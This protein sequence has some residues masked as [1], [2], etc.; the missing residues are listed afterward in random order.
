MT[1]V[2]Q[3]LG[4]YLRVINSKDDEILDL[5]RGL[6]EHRCELKKR[7]DLHK[8]DVVGTQKELEK[9]RRNVR[10]M[11]QQHR[12]D[13]E[14]INRLVNHNEDMKVQI[15]GFQQKLAE[16]AKEVEQK[17]QEHTR[18]LEEAGQRHAAEVQ[19]LRVELDALRAEQSHVR[20]ER[21][22]ART[23]IE[24]AALREQQLQAREVV[25][26]DLRNSL[27]SVR[28]E[29][30]S[31]VPAQQHREV[32]AELKESLRSLNEKSTAEI[33][34]LK[35]ELSR[36]KKAAGKYVSSLSE[37]EASQAQ[38][39][40]K[41]V[42]A[43]QREE[44]AR[45][46][47]E[48][49]R[50]SSKRLSASQQKEIELARESAEQAVTRLE[51]ATLQLQQ[52][53]DKGQAAE[54]R[55]TEMSEALKQE[56][57]R[58]GQERERMSLQLSTLQTQ[59]AEQQREAERMQRKME[60][61]TAELKVCHAAV[62]AAKEEGLR[63]AAEL[64]ERLSLV[65]AE[66][67]RERGDRE[68]IVFELKD[69]QNQLSM[70][71]DRS[72][73]EKKM[74]VVKL[75]DA[76]MNIERMRIQLR[77]K[78]HEQQALLSAQEKR[79]QEAEWAH[80]SELA[81]C[82]K[83]LEGEISELRQRLD[84]ANTRMA[85]EIANH[86]THQRELVALQETVRSSREE[87]ERR[88]AEVREAARALEDA[89]REA[90]SFRE[91]LAKQQRQ[92]DAAAGSEARLRQ[93]TGQLESDRV[94]D[95]KK[96]E[97]LERALADAKERLG[98]KCDEVLELRRQ[99]KRAN[100]EDTKRES[101]ELVGRLRE[102]QG[103]VEQLQRE[104]E[105]LLASVEKL[106]ERHNAAEKAQREA[107]EELSRVN[108]EL[109]KKAKECTRVAQHAKEVEDLARRSCEELERDLTRRDATIASL[110]QEV[111]H[112]LEERAKVV[113][114]E[115][116][117]THQAD[118]NR[119]DTEA[120]QGRIALLE[121]EL[122]ARE[123]QLQQQVAET[124]SIASQLR[125]MQDRAGALEEMVRQKEKK[126]ALRKE[127]LRKALEQVDVAAARAAEAESELAKIKASREK[128]SDACKAET[129]RLQERLRVALEA[130]HAAETRLTAQEVAL[131]EAMRTATSSQQAMQEQQ[132][133]C[134]AKH[135]EELRGAI[136]RANMLGRETVQAKEALRAA[137]V[138]K[139]EALQYARNAHR[140]MATSYSRLV[141]NFAEEAM[142]TKEMFGDFAIAVVTRSFHQLGRVAHNGWD[143]AVSFKQHC[144]EELQQQ[145]VKLRRELDEL[146]RT[147]ADEMQ[148]VL[149]ERNKELS[150]AALQHGSDI[151]QLRQE[152]VE[153]ASRATREG[154]A[155][156]KEYRRK[157]EQFHRD[158][159][160][161]ECAKLEIA[162]QADQIAA[163]K[164][165]LR[166]FEQRSEAERSALDQE[167]RSL[168]QQRERI[169]RR[170]DDCTVEQN[171][172]EVEVRE[173]RS[174]LSALQQVLQEKESALASER[175]RT[176]EENRRLATLTAAKETL[177][178]QVEENRRQMQLLQQQ[179]SAA[180]QGAQQT[181]HTAAAQQS[182]MEERIAELTR[183]L[184][185]LELEKR[186]LERQVRND[187]K[188]IGVFE[189][190]IAESRKREAELSSQLQA[191]KVE[192]SALKERCAN[193]ES[194][195]NIAEVT[196]AETRLREKDLVEKMEEMRSAQQLMQLCFDK[197]QEQLE[198]GRRM[199]EHDVN[200]SGFLYK[201]SH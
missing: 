170:L 190:E 96:N 18:E 197:Q 99:L 30:L 188:K 33:R 93:S 183:A 20:H 92:I 45:R 1:H 68:R 76:N 29:M 142:I 153:V 65:T 40:K 102:S 34:D 123:A 80:K 118:I 111:P 158:R 84:S 144:G 189:K 152:I 164:E 119:R 109:Q 4:E 145:Q 196:L 38:L 56:R 47:L 50:E 89:R 129:Q 36:V 180:R 69:A 82:R 126:H 17:Q 71:Q 120:L 200:R 43:L 35:V 11:E 55:L 72:I 78:E 198:V 116:R 21:E 64:K 23:A 185:A 90:S 73:D 141:T 48:G 161:L 12:K 168:E 169:R 172:S 85:E 63:G 160:E 127:A 103:R 182:R 32:V 87:G 25:N 195:K 136:E 57:E 149:E 176:R 22:A 193:L 128:S 86:K 163:L 166:S 177:H 130:Q 101:A 174:E 179:L 27:A 104:Q 187:E 3:L 60:A 132:S 97:S 74:L 95:A 61:G 117:L 26:E 173:L 14:D 19:S 151:A 181:G 178:N 114:L 81:E 15:H 58:A 16:T 112:L 6:E 162:H 133:I 186:R 192:N 2:D 37:L 98:E 155:T 135:A 59:T 10:K 137:E 52:S 100:D 115:E 143:L 139:E 107:N 24:A 110:Q 88:A 108:A 66:R 157:E 184:N 62:A 194:L 154:E 191:R 9:S 122:D 54:R 105:R 41:Q 79:L 171:Q 175:E 91:M 201:D 124:D 159:T 7:E 148:A 53:H 13:E 44:E 5:I 70:L 94:A 165:Q 131:A 75:D 121:K 106:Q 28:Q 67:D 77:D 8:T 46:Q 138:E 140:R 42:E 83:K 113:V 49:E 146:K 31:M 147:H 39:Q 51:S 134:V 156:M 167:K 199:H 125:P 150:K